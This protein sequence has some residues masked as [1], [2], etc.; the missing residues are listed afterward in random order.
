MNLDE[1]LATIET[2]TAGRDA[3]RTELKRSR[4]WGFRLRREIDAVLYEFAQE[5]AAP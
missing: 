1:A 3:L 2:L 4:D 5:D